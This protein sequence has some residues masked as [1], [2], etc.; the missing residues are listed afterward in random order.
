MRY[1]SQHRSGT[2]TPRQLGVDASA[3]VQLIYVVDL[4]RLTD[5]TG[6]QEPGLQDPD[7]Q[8]SYY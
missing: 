8:K 5:T 2:L 1:K 4:R 7:V 3:P 6:M